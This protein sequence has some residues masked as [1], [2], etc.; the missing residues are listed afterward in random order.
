M[1]GPN[2]VPA[3]DK[4][5]HQSLMDLVCDKHP[6]LEQCEKAMAQAEEKPWNVCVIIRRREFLSKR[7]RLYTGKTR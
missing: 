7:G 6:K 1:S 4:A 2:S 3:G 5:L